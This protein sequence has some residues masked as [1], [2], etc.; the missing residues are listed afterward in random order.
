MQSNFRSG[1]THL[2]VLAAIVALAGCAHSISIAP[3]TSKI[4]GDQSTPRIQTQV[5]YFISAKD[6]VQQVVTP[7]GGGDS[8]KYVPYADLEP[9]LARVLSNVSAGVHV[10]K[11]LQ[12]KQFLEDKDIRFVFIPTITTESSS[13]NNFFWPPTDFTVSL[14][15][16][17]TD[18]QSREV[19]K[20]TV[21]AEGG[22]IA[23]K[24]TFSDQG[25]AGRRA[26]ENASKLLQTEL[27]AAPVFRQ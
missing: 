23:V 10:V 9:G 3:D 22:L 17:A 16:L 11:D 24:Q 26:A 12:D 25:I 6:R 1:R 2:L 27:E 8:V 21:R 15:C 7:A 18:G 14:E 20:K 19:W 5:G 4:G 13:R